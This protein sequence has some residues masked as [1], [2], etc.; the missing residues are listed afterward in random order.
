MIMKKDNDG[1]SL[2]CK[3]NEDVENC[4]NQ[5]GCPKY[6]I[7]RESRSAGSGADFTALKFA[8]LLKASLAKRTDNSTADTSR[9]LSY[10]KIHSLAAGKVTVKRL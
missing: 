3:T 10:M 7:A 4:A 8:D 1:I 6:T 5:P 9:L 2:F